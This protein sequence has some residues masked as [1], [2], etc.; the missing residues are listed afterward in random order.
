MELMRRISWTDQQVV[1]L[2]SEADNWKEPFE[3]RQLKKDIL[4][5]DKGA[6]KQQLKIITAEVAILNTFS[7][8]VEKD[9]A[10]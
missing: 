1:E 2:C 7:N 8:Q 9:I 3:S 4:D 10:S 5:E 6:L